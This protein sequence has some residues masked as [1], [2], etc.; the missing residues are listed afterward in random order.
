MRSMG[1]LITFLISNRHLIFCTEVQYKCKS[2]KVQNINVILSIVKSW[3]MCLLKTDLFMV[4][5]MI[6]PHKKIWKFCLNMQ[7]MAM[8]QFLR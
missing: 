6:S 1:N 5:N 3:V 7:L 8:S 2:I 4:R